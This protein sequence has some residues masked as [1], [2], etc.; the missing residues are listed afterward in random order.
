MPSNRLAL[1]AHDGKKADMVAWA[2]F[3]RDML[4]HY[5]LVAT[6]STAKLLREKVGLE[7][8]AVHPGPL[9]GDAQI[10]ARVVEGEVNAVIFLVDPLD[11]HPHEP[12]IQ[13]LLRLCNVHNIPLATNVST[14]DCIIGWMALKPTLSGQSS[15][16]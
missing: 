10:G 1:I 14:A 6:A 13:A 7:V 5:D 16:G 8:E 4:S 12:D 9:G 15:G 11:K 2:T 3:N